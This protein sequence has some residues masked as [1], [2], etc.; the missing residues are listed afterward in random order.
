MSSR[1]LRLYLWTVYLTILFTYWG[2]W[3]PI[4]SV[5]EGLWILHPEN[6]IEFLKRVI[7]LR[8]TYGWADIL[9]YYSVYLLVSPFYLY[10]LRFGLIVPLVSINLIIWFFRGV[11]SYMAIQILFFMGVIAGF[12]GDVIK[13]WW[14][15]HRHVWRF[16][17]RTIIYGIFVVSLLASMFSVFGLDK[18]VSTGPLSSYLISKNRV[19]NWYFDK[20]TVGLGR[21]LLSPLWILALYFG[22]SSF[23][24]PIR[25]WLGWLFS[26]FGRNSLR[27]YIVHSFVI[28]PIPF[29]VL[30]TGYKSVFTNSFITLGVVLIVFWITDLFVHIN[31]FRA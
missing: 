6:L 17:F 16:K 25:K 2:N 10:L 29:L 9:P 20:Q 8:Y 14:L 23:I 31:R 28:Y 7:T 21:W 24:K 12:Y 13:K 1:S 19:L 15:K 18:V 30:M 27:S 5:K 26:V 11:N 4:G 22:F 3:M